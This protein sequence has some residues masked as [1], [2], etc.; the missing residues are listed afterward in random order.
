[1]A[2]Q[3][4]EKY[5]YQRRLLLL[6]TPPQPTSFSCAKDSSILGIQLYHY[7]RTLKRRC[8]LT[9]KGDARS[10]RLLRCVTYYNVIGDVHL[11]AS[12]ISQYSRCAL[13]TV[14]SHYIKK[15][16]R[17][18]RVTHLT[19]DNCLSYSGTNKS[20]MF[21]EACLRLFYAL[22]EF[23]QAASCIL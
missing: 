17:A 20:R 8:T 18:I 16:R 15:L 6:L 22:S 4:L 7:A 19:L 10:S 5:S 14:V 3:H 13:Q 21:S 2:T 11:R 1:M 12:L 23:L 9:K